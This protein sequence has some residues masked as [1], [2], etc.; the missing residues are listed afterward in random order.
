MKKKK[1]VKMKM[2]KVAGKTGE[3]YYY[4][5]KSL[6]YFTCPHCD[7]LVFLVDPEDKKTL[8]KWKKQKSPKKRIKK[9]KVA[10]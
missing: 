8:M 1:I 9:R 3:A 10:K 2:T 7:K 4:T 5:F 6:V